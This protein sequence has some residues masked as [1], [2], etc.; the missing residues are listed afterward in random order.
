[1]PRRFRSCFRPRCRRRP[2][3]AAGRAYPS[4]A[5][6]VTCYYDERRGQQIVGRAVPSLRLSGRW[7][8][9]CGFAVGDALEVTVGDGL[10]LI[11]RHKGGA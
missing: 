9:R 3:P 8:E 10:L 11:S 6:W 7:L 2:L 4:A 5:R 1:M